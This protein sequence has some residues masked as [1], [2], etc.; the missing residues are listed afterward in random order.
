[1][2]NQV[3][4]D[5]QNGMSLAKCAAKYQEDKRKVRKFLADN[6]INIRDR[7]EQCVLENQH[8]G[9]S[10]NHNYFSVIDS[11]KKAYYLGFIA[12]DG[13][14]S[15]K[16]NS[17]KIALSEVDVLQLKYFK[18]AIESRAP[19]KHYTTNNGF[20]IVQFSISSKQMKY[21]L[22]KYSIVPNKTYKGL[23]MK[24]IPEQYQLPFFFGYYDGDGSFSWN[25][26]TRQGA[27]KVTGHTKGI[28]EEFAKMLPKTLQYDLKPKIYYA[29]ERNIYSLEFSTLPSIKI[30]DTLYAFTSIYWMD[31]KYRKFQEFK[32]YRIYNP[33]A[34]T[35][36]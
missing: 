4:T 24:N 8:R 11:D 34:K 26:N 28:L 6:G 21:D 22:Q 1:M 7:R 36:L 15:S 18:D 12:A 13:C 30:L 32:D 25:K 14:V 23:S 9:Y 27:L 35:S 16:N 33:R 19:I 10:L 2:D 5:Y 29:K 17:I 31:R 3:I 20:N